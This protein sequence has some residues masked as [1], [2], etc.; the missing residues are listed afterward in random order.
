MGYLE[1]VPVSKGKN[2][3]KRCRGVNWI[4]K[5]IVAGVFL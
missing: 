4:G 1:N 5:E 3:I 2:D